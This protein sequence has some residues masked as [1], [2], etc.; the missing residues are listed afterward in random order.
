MGALRQSTAM[1][2]GV[3]ILLFGFSV[4]ASAAGP[5]QITQLDMARAV[6]KV[7]TNAGNCETSYLSLSI[8]HGTTRFTGPQSANPAQETTQ[9]RVEWWGESG[10]ADPSFTF[11]PYEGTTD[12]DADHLFIDP[13][14]M[15]SVADVDV[16]VNGQVFTLNLIWTAFGDPVSTWVSHGDKDPGVAWGEHDI[17]RWEGAS[18][19]G[20]V[21]NSGPQVFGPAD[22]DW[23]DLGWDLRQS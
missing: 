3:L 5:T 11:G 18:I 14:A 22:L 19:E 13:F 10:C 8:A 21:T 6:Y 16:Q 7:V 4:P 9:A 15:A 23:A 1:T 12:T 20:A 2:V 17:Q